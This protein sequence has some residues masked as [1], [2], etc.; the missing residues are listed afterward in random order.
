MNF[1]E[2]AKYYIVRS[3]WFALFNCS[4]FCIPF[5]MGAALEGNIS[6]QLIEWGLLAILLG[7]S[8]GVMGMGYEVIQEQSEESRDRQEDLLEI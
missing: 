8:V 2:G 6:Y 1:I 7:I 5:L 4:I 3:K